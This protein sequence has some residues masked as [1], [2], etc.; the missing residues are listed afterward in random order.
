MSLLES[1]PSSVLYHEISTWMK[2]EEANRIF[3]HVP[4]F[5][6]TSAK[7]DT[8]LD[9]KRRVE[10]IYMEG[11][12][13]G[14]NDPTEGGFNGNWKKVYEILSKGSEERPDWENLMYIT[15][16]DNP[17]YINL[18][19]AVGLFN[20]RPLTFIIYIIDK[21]LG[22]AARY[23]NIKMVNKLL[24]IPIPEK[25]PCHALYDSIEYNHANV[26]D[27]LLQSPRCDISSNLG[28]NALEVAARA[29]NLYLVRKLLNDPKLYINP[30]NMVLSDAVR[31]GHMDIIEELLKDPKM[32][33]FVR[34][35]TGLNAACIEGKL[36]IVN[37]FLQDSRIDPTVRN[38]YAMELAKQYGHF[39]I[40]N[41]L[42][43]DIRVS[44]SIKDK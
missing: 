4:G 8:N 37:R 22:K 25:L 26:T 16:E 11:R 24:E 33:E 36:S 20:K 42:M 28:S 1:I 41:R 15:D 39:D 34:E 38:N 40:V 7:E 29:G 32:D 2:S 44:S 6:E 5:L 13:L 17:E 23:G 43:R 3:S 10:I 35:G 31:G 18:A 12:L 19:V 30:N 9:W 14:S 27:V 21:A